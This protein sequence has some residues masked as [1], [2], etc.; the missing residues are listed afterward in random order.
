MG[1]LSIYAVNPR[2]RLKKQKSQQCFGGIY[3]TILDTRMIEYESDSG[4]DELGAQLGTYIDEK[5]VH[6]FGGELSKRA[7]PE[8][9]PRL[10]FLLENLERPEI[11]AMHMAN[12][13]LNVE[14]VRPSDLRTGKAESLIRGMD[15]LTQ[16]D[17]ETAY[18]VCKRDEKIIG[19]FLIDQIKKKNHVVIN[20]R[21]EPFSGRSDG[22][23]VLNAG[24][25][26]KKNAFLHVGDPGMFYK[27]YWKDTLVKFLYSMMPIW[28][29]KERRERGFAVF[30]G[31]NYR[32]EDNPKDIIARLRKTQLYTPSIT[33]IIREEPHPET[34]LTLKQKLAEQPNSENLAKKLA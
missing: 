29:E 4:L 19:E 2:L 18:E 31:P 13:G 27:D 28:D 22:H 32:E 26:G 1:N 24:I 30:S 21:Q 25:E 14:V 11:V 34:H 17:L 12:F 20:F 10:G 9:D 33:R 7:V 15:D 6:M 23:Y 16:L 3:Q 5:D 8:S